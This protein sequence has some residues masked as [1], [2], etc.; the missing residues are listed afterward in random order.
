MN[1]DTAAVAERPRA[2]APRGSAALAAIDHL[3]LEQIE[4]IL[5]SDEHYRHSPTRNYGLLDPLE[6]ASALLFR[7]VCGARPA[8]HHAVPPA[9]V[10]RRVKQ[11][12]PSAD[13]RAYYVLCGGCGRAGKPSLREWGAVV[14]W[15]YE[16][17]AS[18]RGSLDDF[19]FFNLAG[20]PV[21]E[22]LEYLESIR[23]DLALRRA[24]ARK[25]RDRGE[26]VGRRFMA[27]ID[28]YLGW[29]NV[30]LRVIREG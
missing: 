26:D 5:E 22:R 17:A 8:M 18:R 10:L 1:H 15:N 29:V 9:A 14:D 28:A 19:P 12:L 20:V 25:R 27:K 21:A 13:G 16:A 24:Q 6:G 7:C 3:S 23:Y 4:A 11:P 2:P 30:A